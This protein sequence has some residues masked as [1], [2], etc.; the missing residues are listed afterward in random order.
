[1]KINM[2]VTDIEESVPPSANILSTTNLDGQITHISPDFVR[3]SGF[4]K[5]ELL[6]ENHHI[7]RH[8]D[9]PAEVFEIF[10]SSLKAGQSWMG[11]VKN[12]C[13]NGNHYWVDAYVTPIKQA[14]KIKEYQS[15]RRRPDS[16][17]TKRAND[18]YASLS[19]GKAT[20]RLKRALSLRTKLILW[21]LIPFTA[22]MLSSTIF[23]EP[24]LLAIAWLTMVGGLFFILQP[25]Q[26]ALTKAR[27]IIND[28]LTTYVY[29]GRNDDIGQLL[30]AY[31]KQESET[32]GLIGRI[33]DSAD[34]LNL[35]IGDL[36]L[37][38]ARSQEDLQQEVKETQQVA[39]AM[40]EMALSIQDVANNA[41]LCSEAAN[42]AFSEVGHGQKVV[43]ANASSVQSLKGAITKA[44]TMIAGV[45]KSSV[46]IARVLDVIKD[47]AEQTNLLA[48]NAAI[49]AARAG[50]AGRG[51]AVV[52]DEVRSLATRTQSSTEEIRRIIEEF[53]TGAL[54]AV[55]AMKSGQQQVDQ[56]EDK[57]TKMVKCLE[58]TYDS[59]QKISKMNLQIA[60]AV[61]Q[62]GNVAA[63]INRSIS[64]I[65][66][67]SHNNLT[68]LEQTVRTSRDIH[69]LAQ[70]L[71]DLAKQFWEK[72]NN[73]PANT[74]IASQ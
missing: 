56:C 20:P 30:V 63:D 70:G 10:W 46:N 31:K 33:A 32:M 48:L 59:I 67:S 19:K 64:N 60:T 13:K 34:I 14:G 66:D 42:A 50:E 25:L 43:T 36:S 62:Q 45:E 27:S 61:S 21:V 37:A 58:S 24:L 7:V 71:K 40:N 49:E 23:D 55:A 65:R 72:Q 29:T 2:P 69:L 35:G 26:I 12:R 47:I 52:A 1:M 28:P 74:N 73:Q 18:V 41:R 6:G 51:F 15:I 9:M 38:I 8:P 22:A 3:I 16:Q 39:V 44:A 5:E 57:T 11:T 53:Q 17:I 54:D 68:V 4:E